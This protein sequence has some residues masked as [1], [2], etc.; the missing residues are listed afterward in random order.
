MNLFTDPQEEVDP[1]DTGKPHAFTGALDNLLDRGGAIDDASELL[2]DYLKEEKVKKGPKL[3]KDA[4]QYRRSIKDINAMYP[5]WYT[6]S[7]HYAPIYGGGM[8]KR[9]FGGFADLCGVSNSKFVA[10]Q[11]T[12]VDQVGPHIRKYVSDAK[13]G[14]LGDITIEQN[15][16]AFLQNGGVF[17]ILGYHKPASRWECKPLVVTEATLDAAIARKR[18]SK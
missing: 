3:V 2:R 1:F 15:L 12:T 11:V 7:E 10:V 9:D 6:K 14:G 13:S 18:K 4:A 5:G 16:R 17:V 8:V